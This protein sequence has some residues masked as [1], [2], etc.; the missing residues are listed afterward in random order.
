MTDTYK[1]VRFYLDRGLET[2]RRRTIKKGLTLEEAQTH[3]RDPNTSSN[4]A[5]TAYAKRITRRYG[6]WFDGYVKE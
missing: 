3:C 1:V 2:S 6:A 4:T 5:T